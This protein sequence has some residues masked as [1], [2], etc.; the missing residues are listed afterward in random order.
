MAK[1]GNCSYYMAVFMHGIMHSHIPLHI[2]AKTCPESV[3][4]LVT[5]GHIKIAVLN[6]TSN[7]VCTLYRVLVTSHTDKLTHLT[8]TDTGTELSFQVI[9][10]TTPY[11]TG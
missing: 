11:C 10:R 3:I 9:I 8:K 5:S 1:M 6:K 7:Y 2:L 4:Q